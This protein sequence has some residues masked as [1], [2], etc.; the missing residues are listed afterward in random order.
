MPSAHRNKALQQTLSRSLTSFTQPWGLL[1][2]TS[3]VEPEASRPSV[4]HSAHP[5]P[6]TSHPHNLPSNLASIHDVS[7]VSRFPPRVVYTFFFTVSLAAWLAYDC[8]MP[9]FIILVKL[10]R[11]RKALVGKLTV[12]QLDENCAH[13]G[14]YAASSGNSLLNYLLTYLLHGA[15]SF[16]RS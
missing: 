14:Y 6:F 3:A 8:N 1:T 13:L 5:V 10:T 15:E 2:Q 7:S 9:D 4:G 12:P 16:L 11:R